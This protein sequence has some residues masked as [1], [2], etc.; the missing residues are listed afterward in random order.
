ML[1]NDLKEAVSITPDSD[2][3]CFSVLLFR[4]MLKADS[5]NLGLLA[6]AYP[7]HAIMVKHWRRT[8]EI[9]DLREE[10]EQDDKAR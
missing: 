3:P 6:M 5:I 10:D 2:A 4:L 8:G 7:K 1:S 9:K